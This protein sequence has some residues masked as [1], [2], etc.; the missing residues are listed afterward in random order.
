MALKEVAQFWSPAVVKKG[1]NSGHTAGVC[2]QYVNADYK[3][4][5]SWGVNS[6]NKHYPLL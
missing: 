3:G 2:S 1:K 5:V 6:H 4:K